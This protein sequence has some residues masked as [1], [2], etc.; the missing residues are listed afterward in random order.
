MLDKEDFVQERIYL[1]S[2]LFHI[3]SSHSLRQG[4]SGLDINKES[5]HRPVWVVNC[6]VEVQLLHKQELIVEDYL[7]CSLLVA[8]N[9]ANKLLH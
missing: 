7:G 1:G 6:E 5:L 8:C 4:C 3:T 2:K 9:V